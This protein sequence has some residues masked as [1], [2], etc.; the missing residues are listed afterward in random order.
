MFHRFSTALSFQP[1]R[2][3]KN[4]EEKKWFFLIQE[5]TVWIKVQGKGSLCILRIFYSKCS[6]FKC[7]FLYLSD[8][9][10]GSDDIIYRSCKNADVCYNLSKKFNT[11]Y[12][13]LLDCR[14]CS[15]NDLCNSSIPLFSLVV[16]T[17]LCLFSII[18]NC[19]FI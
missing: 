15:D 18:I 19:L 13:K 11:Q 14:T 10:D 17:K 12:N 6:L 3:R 8:F 16:F 5:S 7:S 1:G 4:D 2:I 9:S